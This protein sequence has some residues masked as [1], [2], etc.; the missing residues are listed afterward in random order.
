[1]S[2]TEHPEVKCARHTGEQTDGNGTDADDAEL[3]SHR[4]NEVE[5]GLVVAGEAALTVEMIEQRLEEDDGDAVVE[6]ALAKNQHINRLAL[7][8][9]DGRKDAQG[10]HRID[11]RYQSAEDGRIQCRDRGRRSLG[12][13]KQHSTRKQRRQHRPNNREGDDRN[14]IPRQCGLVDRQRGLKY[15]GREQYA[16]EQI[17]IERHPVQID[18]RD[19]DSY[20]DPGSGADQDA[21]RRLRQTLEEAQAA[22]PPIRYILIPS[23]LHTS[24]QRFDHPTNNQDGRTDQQNRRIDGPFPLLR[25]SYRVV[26]SDCSAARV[27]L[28]RIVDHGH[29]IVVEGISQ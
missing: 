27:V 16:Q 4:R 20:D 21:S 3:G 11:G 17:V 12:T 19:G 6:Q 22:P 10:R 28:V 15:D 8:D 25:T 7:P 5:G 18:S 24:N 2:T 9:T 29:L 26:R 14:E 1:M 13:N 23:V